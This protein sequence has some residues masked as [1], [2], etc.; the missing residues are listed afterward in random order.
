MA[1]LDGKFLKGIVGNTT[2]KKWRDQQ[3]VQIKVHRTKQTAATKKSANLFGKASSLGKL[4][5]LDLVNIYPDGGMVNRLNSDNR[6]IL[7]QCL[8]KETEQFIFHEQSFSNLAGFEFNV[9]S[10]LKNYLWVKPVLNISGD[11]LKVTLPEIKIPEELNF[12]ANANLCVLSIKIAII[13]LKAG[14]RREMQFQDIDIEI[15]QEIVPAQEWDFIIAEGC[16]C[17]ASLTLQYYKKQNNIQMPLNTKE[18]NPSAIFGA[19]YCPGVFSMPIQANSQ[20]VRNCWRS[21]G[22]QLP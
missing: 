7:S 4:I 9:K 2:L 17:I 16:L 10:R 18:F 21:T 19:L 11:A 8:D 12:P 1:R 5:R 22:L 13:A 20:P 3:I 15:S 6:D 14:Y